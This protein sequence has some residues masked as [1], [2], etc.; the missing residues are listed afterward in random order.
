[1]K[2]PRRAAMQV[3]PSPK[4]GKWPLWAKIL[5]GFTL[6]DMLLGLLA[7]VFLQRYL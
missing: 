2:P 7:L 1:M 3:K 5:L 4:P 6:A